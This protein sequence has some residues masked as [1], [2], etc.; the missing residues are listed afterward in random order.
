MKIN[1][2]SLTRKWLGSNQGLFG[3]L[4]IKTE[5]HG[6]FYFST[7]ENNEHKIQTGTYSLSYCMSPRFK[8]ECFLLQGVPGRSGIRIH[9]GSYPS[10]LQ[11][12]IALG[13][14]NKTEGVPT[15][16]HRSRMSVEIFESLCYKEDNLNINI[17]ED[18]YNET[19]IIREIASGLV[20]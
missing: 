20:A 18:I 2:I 15:M 17:K 14:I 9:P 4:E 13:L 19:K 5:N 11:G 3:I 6:K 12:C 1:Y 10:D 7:L 8:Y 16:L